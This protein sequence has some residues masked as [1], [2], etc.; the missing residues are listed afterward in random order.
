META[1]TEKIVESL[2]VGIEHQNESIDRLTAQMS[3]LGDAVAARPTK[4][5]TYLA[6][7]AVILF[8]AIVG[9]ALFA[10]NRDIEAQSRNIK[11]LLDESAVRGKSNKQTLADIKELSE[12]IDS[13]T[14]LGSEEN[15]AT[16]IAEAITQQRALFVCESQVETDRQLEVLGIPGYVVEPG[17]VTLL[18]EE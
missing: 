15:I 14:E 13:A 5:K 4:K 10:Q 11:V 12:K 9:L 1:R 17:C 6:I 18:A 7:V 2:A 16:Q 8:V 3:V